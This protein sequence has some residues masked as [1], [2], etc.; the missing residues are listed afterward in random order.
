YIL[1]AGGP[2]EQLARVR[3][4]MHKALRELVEEA[5]RTGKLGSLGSI[6]EFDASKDGGLAV[7]GADR[8][9]EELVR[10]SVLRVSGVMRDARFCLEPD[11][12]VSL[13]RELMMLPPDQVQLYRRAGARWAALAAT[14]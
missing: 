10:V 3:W 8:A 7:R 1:A 9:L 11:A 14:A 13:R 2:P 12:A 5:G 6:L 4:P